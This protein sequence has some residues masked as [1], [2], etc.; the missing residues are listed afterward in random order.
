MKNKKL[1]IA[2]GIV[3]IFLIVGTFA[4]IQNNDL[5]IGEKFNSFINESLPT[6][7]EVLNPINGLINPN[8]IAIEKL[9]FQVEEQQKQI[10]QLYEM[11][12]TTYIEPEENSLPLYSCFIENSIK[13]CPGGISGGFKTRCYL[14]QPKQAPW[15]YCLDGWSLQ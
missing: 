1:I 3:L 7:E 15:D 8:L 13:E 4:Q 14:D 9:I 5:R 12:N 11:L 6:E 10:E 2:F